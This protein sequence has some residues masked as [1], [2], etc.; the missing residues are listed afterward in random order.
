MSD[1]A[2]PGTIAAEY[3]PDIS[4]LSMDQRATFR[5]GQIVRLTVVM[6]Q[7]AREAH[8][9]LQ[10]GGS[11]SATAGPWQF[12]K[13]VRQMQA[14]LSQSGLSFALTAQRALDDVYEVYRERNRFVH[15]VVE[16][17]E[18]G[19]WTRE[20]IDRRP[21]AHRREIDEDALKEAVLEIIRAQ[22]RLHGL[23]WLVSVESVRDRTSARHE[24]AEHL[25]DGWLEILAGRFQLTPGGGAWI[26]SEM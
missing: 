9:R 1:A 26:T 22:W 20:S 6:E 17:T 25:Y 10:D 13:L 21:P 18:L 11:R 23:N 4:T 8:V 7:T 15:D 24:D 12:E 2:P 16:E 14:L 5:I 19:R 3:L